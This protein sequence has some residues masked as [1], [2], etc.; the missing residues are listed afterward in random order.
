MAHTVKK[1]SRKRTADKHSRGQKTSSNANK[2][3]KRGWKFNTGGRSK[4]AKK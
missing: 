1:G 2:R 3:A 4:G